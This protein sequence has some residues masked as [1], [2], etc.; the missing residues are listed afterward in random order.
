MGFAWGMRENATFGVRLGAY[1]VATRLSIRVGTNNPKNRVF[2]HAPKGIAMKRAKKSRE[3]RATTK[4]T[5]NK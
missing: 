2:P 5:N 3:S 4:T 1:L